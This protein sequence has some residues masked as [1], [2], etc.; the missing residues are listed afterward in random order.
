MDVLN[1]DIH[2]GRYRFDGNHGLN[3]QFTFIER[4]RYREMVEKVK[5]MGLEDMLTVL[6]PKGFLSFLD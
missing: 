5:E 2:G 1:E 3:N 4:R 6:G